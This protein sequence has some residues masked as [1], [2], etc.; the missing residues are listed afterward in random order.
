MNGQIAL[1]SP[2][3]VCQVID[4][5]SGSGSIARMPSK[6]PYDSNEIARQSAMRPRSSTCHASEMSHETRVSKKGQPRKL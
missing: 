3:Q 5:V 2:P 4:Q 1:V 6:A